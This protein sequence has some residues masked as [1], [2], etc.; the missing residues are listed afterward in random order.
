MVAARRFFGL[1]GTSAV[2]AGF[3][4][5][6]ANTVLVGVPMILKAYG[7]EGA[8]PLF[9]LIAVHLPVT[10]TL[11]TAAGRGTPG[12]ARSRSCGASPPIRSSSPSSP[13]RPVPAVR[14]ARLPAPLWQMVDLIGSAAVSLRPR[15][16]WASRSPLRPGRR[17]GSC[18]P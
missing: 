4:A 11:A 18:P 3:A 12:L 1:T 5:G 16:A 9:L 10:M 14:R 15:S 2:V 6:Q 17:A 13:A 7:E 8:V